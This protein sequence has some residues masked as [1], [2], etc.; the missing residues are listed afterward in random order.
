M[1]IYLPLMNKINKNERK[2]GSS[3]HAPDK[4]TTESAF[5]QLINENALLFHRLKIVADEVH[6]QGEMSGGL[7]SILRG[8]DK[9]G[10]QT[11]PQMA[12]NRSVSRQHIQILVNQLTEAGHL[13]QIDNPAHKRSPLVQLTPRGKKGVKAMN[14]R[15]MKLHTQMDFGVTDQKLREAAEILRAV[16]A[17]FESAQWQRLLKH[18]A[19]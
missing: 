6:H 3:R 7:R 12:R 19:K 4:E 18:L 11:V 8:L 13:E 17:M 9:L 14:R 2:A 15:E 5:D 1:T 16:R 10:P